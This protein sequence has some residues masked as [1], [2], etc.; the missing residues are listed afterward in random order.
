MLHLP[1]AVAVVS[2]LMYGTTPVRAGLYSH[3][4]SSHLMQGIGL[5]LLVGILVLLACLFYNSGRTL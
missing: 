3:R 4:A 5:P 2:L 1:S